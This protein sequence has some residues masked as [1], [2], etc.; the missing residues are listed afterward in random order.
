MKVLIRARHLGMGLAALLLVTAS[1]TMAGPA[2]ASA[3]VVL[4]GSS[5]FGG[6]G[7]NVCSNASG[8][9]VDTQC[10]TETHIGGYPGDANNPAAWWQCVELAQRFY[11]AQGW[12]SGIFSGVSYAYQIYDNVSSLGM[13][14][15]ANGSV[16]SIVI[17]DM[18]IHGS[19]D[20]YSPGAGHV[21]IVD[22]ISGSTI[23]VVEQNGSSTGRA[24]YSLS[25]G[26]LTRSSDV[27]S[28][29]VHDSDNLGANAPTSAS[30]GVGTKLMGDVNGDDYS[31][32][33]VM[34]GDTGTAMV[35]L[36]QSDGTFASPTSWS[37]MHPQY[38]EYF[39]G[40][41]NGD[42]KED[43]VAFNN[44]GGFWDVSLSS[45]TGF[46]TSTQW[47]STE[48]EGSS[49]RFIQDVDGD[50]K[51]DVV[52]YVAA[53][54]KWYVDL[55]SGSGFWGPPTEWISGHGVGSSSQMMGDFNGD[56]KADAAI[57]VQSTGSWYVGLSSGTAFGY[58]SQW[59]YGH[60]NSSNEQL[61]GDVN[62]DGKA[63]VVY[64]YTSN[65]EW[66]AS[67]SAGSGFY[68]PSSWSYDPSGYVTP[69]PDKSFIADVEGDGKADKVIY[70][71][72]WG[73]WY[74]G[75]SSGTGFWS[76]HDGVG[77]HGAN[78]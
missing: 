11:A 64:H 24:T 73:N 57:Y 62:G 69:T 15:Q 65:G 49:K 12:H 4:S 46:W 59:S 26:T 38:R 20:P 30:T 19:A 78:S 76:Y 37:Y 14:R 53:T 74:V 16:T 7:V 13:T 31:D 66:D 3:P 23:N 50:G 35:A 22:S 17:G 43:L 21:A 71:N 61:I 33:V 9:G 56:G 47:A 34:F 70:Y 77:G 5:W 72:P 48:G 55:S 44:S 40:D 67:I 2:Q 28:G 63:D 8:G 42:G 18:I 6:A 27:I 58:P 10:G 41:V 32:A 60:G 25:S 54:G 1:V 29:V 45:G 36:G 39:L 52:F 68:S 51:E 75:F